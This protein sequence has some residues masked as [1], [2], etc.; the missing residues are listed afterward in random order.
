MK[1]P[2]RPTSHGRHGSRAD[3]ERHLDRHRDLLATRT[4]SSRAPGR[5]GARAPARGEAL[6][7][8]RRRPGRRGARR[9]S[10]T[11]AGCRAIRI[12]APP[13]KPTGPRPRAAAMASRR[14][15]RHRGHAGLGQQPLAAASLGAA[16]G[17]ATRG[18]SPERPRVRRRRRP[19]RI[20]PIACSATTARV[21]S[22][23]TRKR[24]PRTRGCAPRPTMEST[25]EP[26][27]M[28]VQQRLELRP[29]CRATREKRRAG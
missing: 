2:P 13:G 14:R 8:T 15:A 17:S 27:G 20:S 4:P 29:Q 3:A 12:S 10:P 5:A 26:V 16:P 18:S 24:R 1:I 23:N 21:A 28:P 22:S 9:R 19:R 6:A 25:P 11:C 7:H